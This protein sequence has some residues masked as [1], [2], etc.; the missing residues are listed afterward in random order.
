MGYSKNEA[1]SQQAAGYSNKIN[2]SSEQFKLPREHIFI[3]II[4]KFYRNI[5]GKK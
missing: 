1:P 4:A 3:R 2:L 5:K